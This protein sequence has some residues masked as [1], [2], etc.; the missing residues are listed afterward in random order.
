MFDNLAHAERIE[1][2]RARTKRVVDH[3]LFVVEIHEWDEL[4]N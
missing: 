2:A 1:I 3:L 4:P